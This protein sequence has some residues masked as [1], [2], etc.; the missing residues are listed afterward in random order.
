MIISASRRT[1][2]P[3]YYGD[4]FL[5]RIQEREV[6]VRNPMNPRQVAQISLSPERVDGIVFWT[7]NPAPMAQRL[8]E[9]KDYPFY[10]QFTLNSYGNE[11]E[12]GL[13]PVEERVKIFQA[14]A[15]Q[16]GPHRVWW[17]YDPI[18]V[19]K[20]YSVSF[21]Q[22]AFRKLAHELRGSTGRVTVSFLDCYRSIEKEMKRMGCRRPS[23]EQQWELADEMASIAG[24]N[25]MRIAACGEEIDFKEAGFF[26]GSCVDAAFLETLSGRNISA[27]K[28]RNQ[29]KMCSC[30]ASVDV[31][32]YESCPNRCRYCYANRGDARTRQQ[33]EKYKKDSPLLCSELTER[34]Q[35]YERKF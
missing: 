6:L 28:D 18:L 22:E 2:I 14:L 17:R 23:A 10:F 30:A 15:K 20:A 19:S 5:K 12:P 25:G 24:E 29:R 34:D 11:I 13:P 21:H 27:K 4:W 31:G 35:V 7:K 33:Y 8:G 3:N 32:V 1:D 9:L 16:I 26:S